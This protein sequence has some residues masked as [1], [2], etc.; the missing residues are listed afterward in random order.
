MI[1]LRRAEERDLPAMLRLSDEI[2]ELHV[3]GEPQVY[4]RGEAEERRAW[5]AGKLAEDAW[6]W[7]AEDGGE[8]VGLLLLQRMDRPANPFTAARSWLMVDQLV[9]GREAQRRGVGQ[10]LMAQAEREARTLGLDRL[11]LDVRA[12]NRAAIGFYEALGYRP[13][14][15]RMYRSLTGEGE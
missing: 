9:V 5:Y 4:H 12:F 15:L 14:A 6:F 1:Q 3:Q 7:V 13:T 11:E 10:A 2:Q 8:L